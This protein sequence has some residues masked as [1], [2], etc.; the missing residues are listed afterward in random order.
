MTLISED[1]ARK[2]C[3]LCNLAY[4]SWVTHK[5][6]FDDNANPNES[7][8]KAKYFMSRLSGITQ[9]YC[10]LQ[11]AKLHD[12]AIQRGSMNLT[13]DYITRFGLWEK[14]EK[15]V[16]ALSQKLEELF[17]KIKTARHKALCHNDLETLFADESVGSFAGGLDKEYFE[18]LQ[19]LA[20]MVYEKWIGGPYPFNDLAEADVEEFLSLLEKP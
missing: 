14:S 1:T 12:P 16:T 3:E 8:G 18:A 15:E 9:E 6:L 2:F 17:G 13:I 4:E 7:I 20:N 19:K 10:L 5:K 11:I